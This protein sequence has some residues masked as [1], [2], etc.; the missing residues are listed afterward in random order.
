MLDRVRIE[1]FLENELSVMDTHWVESQPISEFPL[2][3]A[4]CQ[5]KLI[6]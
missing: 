3:R 5:R 2:M 4:Y 1:S 6:H